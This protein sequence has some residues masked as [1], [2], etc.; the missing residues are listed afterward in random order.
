MNFRNILF[1]IFALTISLNAK[2]QTVSTGFTI[3]P[4]GVKG[5]LDEANLSSY[6]VAAKG[7]SLIHI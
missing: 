2:A 3:I 6:M 7:L 1:F 4:L 5:G